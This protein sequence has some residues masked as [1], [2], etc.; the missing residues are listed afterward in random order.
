MSHGRQLALIVGLL[1]LLAGLVGMAAVGTFWQ[2]SVC[3]GTAGPSCPHPDT[4]SSTN[5][6]EVVVGATFAAAAIV[7]GGLVLFIAAYFPEP[8]PGLRA[9]MGYLPTETPR[10]GAGAPPASETGPATA[11][12]ADDSRAVPPKR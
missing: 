8:L 5:S 11:P 10:D 12:A 6:T 7:T 9:R 2:D 4:I 3:T 1:V